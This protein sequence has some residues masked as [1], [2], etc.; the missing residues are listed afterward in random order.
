MICT[1]NV[2]PFQG[3]KLLEKANPKD[4]GFD[5]FARVSEPVVIPPM[6]HDYPAYARIPLGFT[7]DVPEGFEAQIRPKSGMASKGIQCHL[8]TVDPDY[9]GEVQ[10][11]LYNFSKDPFE[12]KPNMKVCQLVMAEAK[13]WQAVVKEVNYET[14][15]GGGFGSTGEF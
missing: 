15:R 7:I 4:V 11:I 1:F 3:G 5:C 10:C 12:V 6:S 2:A 14:N 9:R 8:G 13:S